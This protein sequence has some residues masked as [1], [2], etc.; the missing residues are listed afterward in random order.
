MKVEGE[1]G[2]NKIEEELEEEE[3]GFDQN[4]SYACR[5]LSKNIHIVITLHFNMSMH[6]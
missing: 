5:K 6:I 2:A 1:S 4:M 3:C